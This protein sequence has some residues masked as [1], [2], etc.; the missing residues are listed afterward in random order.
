MCAVGV[1]VGSVIWLIMIT[2]HG[3]IVVQEAVY[4]V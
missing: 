2:K 1:I 3:V 4:G